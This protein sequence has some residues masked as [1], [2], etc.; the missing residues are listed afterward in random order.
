MSEKKFE[1]VTEDV[2]TVLNIN[3]LDESSFF[4]EDEWDGF[5]NNCMSKIDESDV[6]DATF[7]GTTKKEKKELAYNEIE[8]QL[9]EVNLIS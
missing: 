3:G 4:D 6:E 8:A 5:V 1:V 9:R 2:V 7:F